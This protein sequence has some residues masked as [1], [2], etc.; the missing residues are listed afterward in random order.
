MRDRDAFVPWAKDHYLKTFCSRD[1]VVE[2]VIFLISVVGALCIS[3]GIMKGFIL[4]LISS[5]MSII[6]F[7]KQKQYPLSMQ[8]IV[9]TVTNI[10]GIVHHSEEIFHF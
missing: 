2:T 6:Y 7:I 3:Y 5:L 9:F 4:W 10:L 1:R 8:Q